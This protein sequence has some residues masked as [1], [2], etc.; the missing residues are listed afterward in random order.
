MTIQQAISRAIEGGYDNDFGWGTPR[1]SEYKHG[2]I[3][4]SIYSYVLD[5]R[6]WQSLGKSLGWEDCRGPKETCHKEDIPTKDGYCWY[7]LMHGLIT[8][9]AEGKSIESYF[10][11]L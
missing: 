7:L 2:E 3:E 10:E 4:A 1:W 5:P 8:H 6:W 11:T 9:L